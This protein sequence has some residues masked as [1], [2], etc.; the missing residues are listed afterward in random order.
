MEE[1]HTIPEGETQETMLEHIKV[2]KKE[3]ARSS[4]RN[5][6]LVKDLMALTFGY[7]RQSMLKE[8][9]PVSQLIQEYPALTT[10]FG[11]SDILFYKTPFTTQL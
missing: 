9:V 1:C 5:M 8:V 4:N 10:S 2:M 7:R 3:M 11:V 6:A